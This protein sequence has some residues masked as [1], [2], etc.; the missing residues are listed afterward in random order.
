MLCLER[1]PLLATPA[2]PT[3]L[4][5]TAVKEQHR[6]VLV[7]G[8]VLASAA[9]ARFASRPTSSVGQ[10]RGVH[11]SVRS[12]ICECPSSSNGDP[13]LT[14]CYPSAGFPVPPVPISGHL[15]LSPFGRN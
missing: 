1:V 7:H 11:G 5:A 14:K 8:D 2:K 13:P 12:K 15:A 6:R 4:T 10:G 3:P 9:H